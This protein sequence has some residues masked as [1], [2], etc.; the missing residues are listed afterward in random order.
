VVI[1]HYNDLENLKRCLGLL[2]T[3]S[4]DRSSFEIVVADNNSR[5]GLAAVAAA[6]ADYGP[7]ARAVP[8]PMQGAGPARNVAVGNTHAPV[9]AFID[10]DCRPARDWLEKGLKSLGGC[11][12]LGGRVDTL[13]EDPTRPTAVEAFEMVFAFNFKNYIEKEGFTGAGNMFTSRRV[14]DLVGPFR[15]G[16]SEDLDWSQR[17]VAL[18]YRLRYDDDTVVGHPA[19]RDMAELKGKWKRI[20]RE[21]FNV[22]IK[23]PHGSLKWFLRSFAVLASPL[24]HALAIMRTRKLRSPREKIAA[25]SVLIRIRAWR[26]FQCLHALIDEDRKGPC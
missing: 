8:A 1:P 15:N 17:A 20:T 11:D 21:S 14:F 19:R 18:G 13:P 25:I 24:P 5:C 16:V 9:L 22:M 2:K 10:S 4:L 6:C 7:A 26:F 23:K 3:Q 12:V